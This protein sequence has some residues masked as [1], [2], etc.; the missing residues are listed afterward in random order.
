M[1]AAFRTTTMRIAVVGGGPAGLYFGIL[2]KRADPA[3]EITVYE[4][5]KPDDTFGFGVVF[6]DVA[7][8]TL[9]ASDAE[10]YRALAKRLHHWD[11]IEIHFKGQL[12]RSSGHG[13]SGISR[14]VLLET[15]EKR[16]S[17]LGVKQVYSKEIKSLGEF[18]GAD[19]V[20]GADGG[21]STIRE[22]LKDKFKPT[23]D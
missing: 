15:L 17:E 3:H 23:V 5:N 19:L 21:N 9:E 14:Q 2:M 6:S 4:R 13:F 12:I 8:E 16:A 10:T 7:I 11:D 22:L 18:K 20:V 1:S